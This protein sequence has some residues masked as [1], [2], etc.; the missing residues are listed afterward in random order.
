[1][2][3]AEPE[4]MLNGVSTVLVLLL[5]APVYIGTTHEYNMG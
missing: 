5:L 3:Q 1:M 2:S 4:V